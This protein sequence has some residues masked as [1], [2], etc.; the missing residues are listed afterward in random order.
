[1]LTVLVIW[2]LHGNRWYKIE[3]GLNLRYWGTKSSDSS[4]V[5]VAV[6][7]LACLP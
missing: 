7:D 2:F 6:A 3:N 4:S 1:L 5:A